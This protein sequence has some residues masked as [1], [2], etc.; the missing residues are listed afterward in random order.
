[1]SST[2]SPVDSRYPQGKVTVVSLQTYSSVPSGG[3]LAV[4]ST[5]WT[6]VTNKGGP[7]SLLHCAQTSV[8]HF[9][10]C[11]VHKQVWAILSTALCTNK[12]GPFSLLHCAQTNVGHFLYCIVHKQVGHFIYCIVHKQVW[13][14]LSTALCTNKCG[15]FYQL[16]C[17]QTRVG[18]FSGALCI[19][20]ERQTSYWT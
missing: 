11:I 14:I 19:I 17:A 1:M 7:F 15:P 5:P 4:Q 6:T 12:C 10:Y 16:H 8:G 9:L 13:A 2:W 18:H 3:E 20:I